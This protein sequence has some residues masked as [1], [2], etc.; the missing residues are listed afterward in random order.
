MTI[1]ECLNA[2]NEDLKLEDLDHLLKILVQRQEELKLV[3]RRG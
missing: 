3:S 2:N 1:I